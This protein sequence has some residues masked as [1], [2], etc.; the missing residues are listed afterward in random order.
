M[1]AGD[2]I[3]GSDYNGVQ[4]TISTVLGTYYGQTVN[5]GQITSP[6]TTKISAA[7]W[8]ALYTDILTCYDHQNDSAGSLTWPTTST[9]VYYSDFDAYRTTANSCSTNYTQFNSGYY[10]SQT[11]ASPQQGP[12]WGVNPGSETVYH[13]TTCTWTNTN[14]ATYFF[15]LGG[16]LRITAAITGGQTG[17]AGTKDYSWSSMLSHMGTVKISRDSTTQT[18]NTTS[19]QTVDVLRTDVGYN[20]LNTSD[21]LIFQMTSSS[22][23]PNMVQ[24]FARVSGSS[25]LITVKYEDRSGQ[26]NAP[27]GTDETVTGTLTSYV[28]AYGASGGPSF[29]PPTYPVDLKITNSYIP[30]VS[31]SGFITASGPV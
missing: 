19:G 10:T 26:P 22:Y 2:K 15:N 29:N 28:T 4:S 1:A 20:Q 16:Q 21:T 7:Q 14:Q 17:T 30:S 9:R 24:I 23:N 3:Y 6:T 11:V 5:S 31:D 8:Q 18:T 27:Y 13:T 25:L 12:G